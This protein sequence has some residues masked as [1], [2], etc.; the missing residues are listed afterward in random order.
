MSKIKGFIIRLFAYIPFVCYNIGSGL[1]AYRD[2]GI[3]TTPMDFFGYAIASLAL[4]FIDFLYALF[5]EN[6]LY[7]IIE[8]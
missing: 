8:D 2:F 7:D 6:L 1:Y 5:I 3:P 4:F